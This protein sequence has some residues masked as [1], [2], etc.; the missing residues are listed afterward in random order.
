MSVIIIFL[1]PGAGFLA[2]AIASVRA[3]SFDDWELLLVDDGS[4]DAS[5][6]LARAEAAAE[7]ERIRYLEH[8]GHANRGMSAS[9]NLGV[10]AALGRYLTFL[11]ADDVYL[12]GR[13]LHHV[14]IL[15]AH[16]EA[17]LVFGRHQL[18]FSWQGATLQADRPVRLGFIPERVYM[19][20][21][22][23]VR[24]LQSTGRYNPGICTLTVRRDAALAVGAF[25]PEF[26]GCYEDQV[27]MSKIFLRYPVFVTERV[28]SRYRQHD[29]SCTATAAESG[30]YRAG[31]PHPTR[32]RYLRWLKAYIETHV[33]VDPDL[34]QALERQLRPYD[35]RWQ[36]NLA[37]LPWDR[38]RFELKRLKRW[39]LR[40][41]ASSVASNARH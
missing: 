6:G 31:L 35:K 5:S 3:Q 27:F 37:A 30:E 15:D 14:G 22:V 25:E 1:D 16:P 7:P 39:L 34:R 18:W 29:A 38:T 40:R 11:D 24:L 36:Y 10:G 19:P 20:P 8:Q 13:L 23:Q 4:S 12:P 41:L 33:P 28:D 2:E 17:A 9:R 32:E 26:R 21:A